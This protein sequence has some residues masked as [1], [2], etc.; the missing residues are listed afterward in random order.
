VCLWVVAVCLLTVVVAFVFSVLRRPPSSFRLCLLRWFS[1]E[2][3]WSV[4][5]KNDEPAEPR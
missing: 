1:I 5:P 3:E 2:A 4:S